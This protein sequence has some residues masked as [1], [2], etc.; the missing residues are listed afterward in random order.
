MH[1]DLI[2]LIKA[3]GY[4]AV[5]GFVFAESGLLIGFF[6]PGDSLLFTAGF[7]ASQGFLDL[8]LLLVGSFIAAVLGDSAG[9]WFGH[10]VGP[11]IFT[12]E[13]SLI[14][15]KRYLERSREFYELHGGK[16]III[17]RFMPIIRTFAPILA[18]VG[19]MHYRKFFAF[20]VI[21]ALIWA[22]GTATLGFFLGAV[23]PN[24]DRYL[25]PILIIIIV[26]SI[27]PGV[28]HIARDRDSRERLRSWW[29]SKR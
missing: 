12:R 27:A 16:T 7:L 8:P 26:V 13:N 25:L 21:G 11:S 15:N 18:G 24:V 9:Y 10:K 20:N 29:M 1:F 2:S 3:G 17:A 22:V 28:V 19:R 14:F 6:L 4:L 5:F 23:I